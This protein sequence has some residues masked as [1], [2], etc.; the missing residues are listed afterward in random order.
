MTDIVERLRLSVTKGHEPTDE[1]AIEAADVERLRNTLQ[2]H[3]GDCQSLNGEVT[4]FKERAE[5]AEADNERLRVALKPFAEAAKCAED[6]ETDDYCVA[7]SSARHRMTLGD[8]RRARAALE[9][10]P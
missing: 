7:G 6:D 2:L 1:D 4:M 9:P 10:K 3:A 8:L 5:A